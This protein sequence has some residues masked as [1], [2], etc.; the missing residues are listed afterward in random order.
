MFIS[1][2]KGQKKI[3]FTIW[4]R[5]IPMREEKYECSSTQPSL[6]EYWNLVEQINN[7]AKTKKPNKYTQKG[8]ETSMFIFMWI[9]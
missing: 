2:T 3:V 6:R 4:A 1:L 8:F 9:F 7:N 5:K